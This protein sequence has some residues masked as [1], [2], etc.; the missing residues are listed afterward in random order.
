MPNHYETLGVERDASQQEIKRA[1][2]KLARQLHPDVAGPEKAEEFK[3]VN[4]A[5]NVLSDE[6][7]RRL[8]DLGGD[9]ALRGGGAG[10]GFGGFSDIFETFFGMGGAQRG[11]VPRGRRGQDALVTLPLDLRDV[12]FGTETEISHTLPVECPTCHGTC[13]APGTEPITC[14]ECSGT[15]TVKR[16]TNSILGQMVT[17][18]ACPACRGHGTIIVTPCSECAGEGRVRAT[19]NVKVKVPAGVEDGMRIR[20]PGRGEAGVEG[21]GAGD[22]FVEV[23]VRQDPAFHR[24]GDDLVCEIEVPMTAAALGCSLDVDTFDGPQTIDIPAGTDSGHVVQLRGLG[25]GRLHRSGRGDLRVIVEVKTPAKLDDA[26]RQILR[27]LAEMR[28]EEL[29]AAR[30][31]QQGGSFFSKLKEKIRS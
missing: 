7:S 27:Q 28:G 12:V 21:G 5:Y 26:Q 13:A 22:L 10:P 23:Q 9:D 19:K 31:V 11:P 2:R 15:G 14:N 1:Y 4:E 3:A 29:P 24:D 20:I 8:Y 25:A 18:M 30:L 6:E 17:Q 16:V